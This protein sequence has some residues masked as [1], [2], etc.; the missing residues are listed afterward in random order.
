MLRFISLGSGSRGNAT[1]IESSATRVLVDC[2]FSARETER[3]L[4]L[5]GVDAATIDALLVTHEH[6][7]HLR[8]AV[9]FARRHQVLLGGTLG[10]FRGVRIGAGIRFHP[11]NPHHGPFPIGDLEVM[12]YPIPHDSREPVQFTFAHA[13]RRLGLLTDAGY[14]TPYIQSSLAGVDALLLECNHDP[15]LLRSGPYPPA[16]QQRVGGDH[17]HL[18][19]HQ[20]AQLLARLDPP[21]LQHL[22]AAH[23]SEK[24]NRPELAQQALLT[25]DHRLQSRLSLLQQD[26]ISSWYRLS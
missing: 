18:S 5:A 20:A 14:I 7:D 21:R 1:L 8:G 16:L 25:V 24:N 2:G 23:L 4:H 10:T 3:R 13:G 12:P 6:G 15:Q 19:N 26:R 11:I 17:G 9:T 22:V